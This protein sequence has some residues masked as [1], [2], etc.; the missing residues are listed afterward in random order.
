MRWTPRILR[1][2]LLP[3][4]ALLCSMSAF[5]QPVELRGQ[6]L[7]VSY[8]PITAGTLR[9][10]DRAS[11]D[12]SVELDREGRFV[13]EGADLGGEYTLLFS[14]S[15]GVVHSMSFLRLEF[16][17]GEELS[18][19][20]RNG[21]LYLLTPIL[22]PP[23]EPPRTRL[24]IRA[25]TMIL[26]GDE[27]HGEFE[28]QPGFVGTAFVQ[29]RV[30]GFPILGSPASHHRWELALSAAVNR[31]EEIPQ[32]LDP[33]A[34]PGDADFARFGGS[35]GWVFS[36]EPE[37]MELGLGFTAA[38]GGIYDGGELLQ[39]GREGEFGVDGYG[40]YLRAAVGIP[41]GSVRLMMHGRVDFLSTKAD[42]GASFWSG[43]LTA[44][45]FGLGIQ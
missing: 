11:F 13:I 19:Q 27:F 45:S 34:P 14:D 28:V 6:L 36:D 40:A 12:Q 30:D 32:R 29:R 2:L 43:G 9:V 23:P 38:F 39:T 16:Y 26:L 24:G 8:L 33:L 10:F 7:G 37:N 21:K 35:A 41:A 25:G 17:R 20:A 4:L 42:H 31:Y 5:A 22:P 3:S 15:W 1:Q 44:L 18:L